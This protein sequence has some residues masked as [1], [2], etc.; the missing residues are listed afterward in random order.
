MVLEMFSEK[1]NAY[2][3]STNI[4]GGFAMN[5]RRY[6]FSMFCMGTIL[7]LIKM[8]PL[9]IAIVVLGIICLVSP[10]VPIFI[11]IVLAGILVV[12][13]ILQQLGY[14]KILLSHFEDEETNDLFDKMFMDNSKGYKNV[15]DTVNEI[16]KNYLDD[17]SHDNIK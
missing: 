13:A 16:I 9:L 12:T 4:I 10:V 17:N 15:T 11:P 8:W 2:I 3:I 5:K 14:M 1:M 6:P 7:N